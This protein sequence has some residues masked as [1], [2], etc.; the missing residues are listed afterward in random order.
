MFAFCSVNF[1][2]NEKEY[3]AEKSEVLKLLREEESGKS[4]PGNLNDY[5]A[6]GQILLLVN[7]REKPLALDDSE[8]L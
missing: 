1:K 5:Y 4:T 8:K 6:L 7:N 3:H 2:K